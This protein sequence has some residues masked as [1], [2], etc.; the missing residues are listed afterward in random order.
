MERR[1]RGKVHD[2]KRE[3]GHL[4]AK[5]A[6]IVLVAILSGWGTSIWQALKGVAATPAV[7]R[8]LNAQSTALA[9]VDSSIRDEVSVLRSDYSIHKTNEAQARAV[10]EAKVD[11]LLAGECL[12]RTPR[13]RTLMQLNCNG[14]LNR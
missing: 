14:R 5:G 7:V 8:N 4:W 12:D 6:W 1:K 13:E 3:L 9:G 10:L 2:A 11:M